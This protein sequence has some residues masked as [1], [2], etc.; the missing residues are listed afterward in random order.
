MLTSPVKKKI[1]LHEYLNIQRTKHNP[2]IFILFLNNNVKAVF[3]PGRSSS[4]MNSALMAYQ[5]SQFMKLKLVPP[6]VVREINGERGIVQ[7]F[8]DGIDGHKYDFVTYLTPVQKSNIYTFY[9]VLGE[10]DNPKRNLLFGKNCR[11]PALID[12]EY[13]LKISFIVFGDYPFIAY[14]IKGLKLSLNNPQEF[15]RFPIDQVR[16]FKK[17]V[18]PLKLKQIF[19]NIDHDNLNHI[20]SYSPFGDD[21]YYVKWKNSYWLKHNFKDYKYVYK[22][23]VPVIF[24]KQTI[25]RLKKLNPININSFLTSYP[26]PK[27]KIFGILYRRDILLKKADSSGMRKIQ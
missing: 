19:N 8:V 4:S 27:E 18:S 15:K 21:F 2:K 3:K 5:F 14:K 22:D 11:K 7:F 6:T 16:H 23:F 24:S 12:N 1:P 20:Y 25:S 17:T 13:S 10:Y 26:I 9:F